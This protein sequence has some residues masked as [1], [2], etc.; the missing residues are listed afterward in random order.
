M[1]ATPVVPS[2][3]LLSVRI[4]ATISPVASTPRCSF[5]QPRRPFPPCL[6]A[7]HSPSPTIDRPLLSMIR[8]M[9]SLPVRL[10]RDTFRF[11]LRRESVVWSGTSSATSISLKSDRRK[12]SIWRSGKWKTSLMVNAVSI[13]RSENFG[14]APR[15]PLGLAFQ[16]RRASGDSQPVTSPRCTSPRSYSRQFVTR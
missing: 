12:P 13:A 8:S 1:I 5:F 2:S 7:A 6:A 9:G 14:C 10:A 11:V 3:T 4:C 16:A 15:R